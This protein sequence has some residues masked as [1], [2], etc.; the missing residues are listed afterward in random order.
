M[1][2]IIEAKKKRGLRQP[3]YNLRKLS[4]GLVSCVVGFSIMATPILASE[5]DL[6]SP[7]PEHIVEVL[8]S[9]EMTETEKV[10]VAENID[11]DRKEETVSTET[12]TP[13]AATEALDTEEGKAK[14][15]AGAGAD[16]KVEDGKDKEK[17]VAPVEDVQA[18]EQ[19]VKQIE[20]MVAPVTKLYEKPETIKINDMDQAFRSVEEKGKKRIPESATSVYTGSDTPLVEEFGKDHNKDYKLALAKYYGNY[21]LEG[22]ANKIK[23]ASEIVR[24][25][26]KGP[27]NILKEETQKSIL[28]EKE[29]LEKSVDAMAETDKV[30]HEAYGKLLDIY[31]KY[32][33]DKFGFKDEDLGRVI[34][35]LNESAEKSKKFIARDLEIYDKLKQFNDKL[36]VWEVEDK[37]EFEHNQQ[38][39]L[40]KL[41]SLAREVD[42]LLDS[43]EKGEFTAILGD[44]HKDLR[45]KIRQTLNGIRKNGMEKESFF[46]ATEAGYKDLKDKVDELETEIYSLQNYF[47][48]FNL[49]EEM[50]KNVPLETEEAKKEL[51]TIKKDF[52]ERIDKIID[53]EGAEEISNVDN[54]RAYRKVNQ[55][56]KQAIKDLQKKDK[57]LKNKPKE[58]DPQE[59]PPQVNPPQSKPEEN[60]PQDSQPQTDEGSQENPQV[61]EEKKEEL[62][63]SGENL[64]TPE[65]NKKELPPAGEMPKAPEENKKEL[66]P[67][68]EMPQ[69]DLENQGKKEKKES[70]K[71]NMGE[72][73]SLPQKEINPQLEKESSKKELNKS[74]DTKEEEKKA[75]KNMEVK[76]DKEKMSPSLKKEETKEA[77]KDKQ[78]NKGAVQS[79]AKKA[80]KTG[81]VSGL[82]V[83]TGLAAFSGSS[84][85]TKL[86]GKKKK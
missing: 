2:E 73:E 83:Y 14:E 60:R 16:G 41:D 62:P 82:L 39:E 46:K 30:V 31:D 25:K 37:R 44:K 86:K 3:K 77:R 55:D 74:G 18:S 65:E 34:T 71:A 48:V 63:P 36:K 26:L 76:K 54:Y 81:D 59:N 8:A 52:Q 84:L 7:A 50:N 38:K 69:N 19:Y 68:E 13:L 78:M 49:E 9:N 67:A 35:A 28:K 24:G 57:E 70:D 20:E 22:L 1:R 33:I 42:S 53:D 51:D 47:F 40:N 10:S 5:I 32:D 61:P 23:E 85:L 29:A 17:E 45:D 27:D 6:V 43:G 58:K 4:V 12:V 72:K 56:Y 64:K 21:M 80:P 15:E 75:P 11:T 66:P 79:D